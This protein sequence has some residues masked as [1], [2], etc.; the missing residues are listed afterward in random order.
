MGTSGWN[1]TGA[2]WEGRVTDAV[3][4]F[5]FDDIGQFVNHVVAMKRGSALAANFQGAQSELEHVT[6]VPSDHPDPQP[7]AFSTSV[8]RP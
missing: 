3:R 2:Y 8:P 1:A 6:I 7:H 5:P 4:S